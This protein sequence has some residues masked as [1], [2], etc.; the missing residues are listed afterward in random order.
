MPR[1]DFIPRP[2]RH[3]VGGGSFTP[4]FAYLPW[5]DALGIGKRNR[6]K[7][8]EDGGV[9]VEPNQPHD[10]SGGAEAEMTWDDD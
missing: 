2:P 5:V 7:G 10:R 3:D 4:G 6:K 1:H 8:P 9:P